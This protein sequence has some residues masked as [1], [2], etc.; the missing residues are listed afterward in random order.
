MNFSPCAWNTVSHAPWPSRFLLRYE[1]LSWC[2]CFVQLVVY[3]LRMQWSLS[4][5]GL[6]VIGKSLPYRS[7]CSLWSSA[8]C[9][10]HP[11]YTW[12]G[13]ECPLLDS[14]GSEQCRRTT[15]LPD[16]SGIWCSWHFS[17]FQC[18]ASCFPVLFSFHPLLLLGVP[19]ALLGTESAFCFPP[20]TE[21]HEETSETCSLVPAQLIFSLRLLKADDLS[22][23]RAGKSRD[24]EMLK[25]T[26]SALYTCK[27]RSL[28]S[29][30]FKS[31]VNATVFWVQTRRT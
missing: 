1:Q 12:R 24:V 27:V 15:E 16:S 26:F 5:L 21:L 8:A 7:H 29:V 13:H 14:E 2:V 9:L 22:L 28:F 19:S 18:T 3:P 17:V 20:A 10:D 6:S 4:G 11:G 23:H 30:A 31:C 25:I